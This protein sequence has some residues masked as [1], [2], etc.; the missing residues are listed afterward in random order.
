MQEILEVVKTTLEPR[1]PPDDDQ[2]EPTQANGVPG[3]EVDSAAIVQQTEDLAL[4]A[5][6]AP[7]AT[8]AESP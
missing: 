8:N 1:P 5:P 7:G 2:T 4:E 3:T 6:V